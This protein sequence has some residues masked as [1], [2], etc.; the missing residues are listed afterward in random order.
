MLNKNNEQPINLSNNDKIKIM[1]K[2]RQEIKG[3]RGRPR[4]R[5]DKNLTAAKEEGKIDENKG[6][7]PKI[8]VASP[9]ELG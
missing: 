9:R 6:K 7:M 3:K 8:K 4:K 2:N 1:N 5:N